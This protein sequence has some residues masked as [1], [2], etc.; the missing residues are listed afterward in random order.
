MVDA[1]GTLPHPGARRPC[2]GFKDQGS[3]SA[4]RGAR[5]SM[6][7][8]ID[9]G[10][11]DLSQVAT[12]PVATCVQPAPGRAERWRRSCIPRLSFAG[13]RSSDSSFR[14]SF[15]SYFDRGLSF[16][17]RSTSDDSRSSRQTDGS[18]R[19]TSWGAGAYKSGVQRFAA[20]KAKLRDPA[21]KATPQ[22]ARARSNDCLSERAASLRHQPRPVSTQERHDFSRPPRHASSRLNS[23]LAPEPHLLRREARRW[24]PLARNGPALAGSPWQA[25]WRVRRPMKIR[26]SARQRRNRRC[27]RRALRLVDHHPA[28]AHATLR[29]GESRAQRGTWL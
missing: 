19:T 20:Q 12:V 6:L 8:R 18:D 22:S 1:A 17:Q 14:R 25:A 26:C 27:T 13:Q 16:G 29:R 21:V 3:A 4:R 9:S 7:K 24:A 23:P 2:C 28:E 5:G 11:I 10:R 15:G